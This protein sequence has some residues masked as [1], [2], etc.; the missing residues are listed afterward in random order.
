MLIYIIQS[1][2]LMNILTFDIEDW[3]I[4]EKAGLGVKSEWRKRLDGYLESILAILDERG[5]KATFFILGK[6][7]DCAPEVVLKID[8]A[9]HHIG[10]HSYSHTFLRNFSYAEAEEDTRKGIDTVEQL[11]GKKVTAYRAPAFSIT[12]ENKYMFEIL[13]KYGIETDASIFPAGR[14][15]GGFAGFES[16]KPLIVQY[17]GIKMKEFPIPMTDVFGKRIAYSGGGYFRLFPY[18]KIKFLVS[19]SSYVMTYFH[20]KD[21]DAGQP[22]RYHGLENESAPI[23]YF[24]NYYGLNQCFS[25]FQKLIKSFDFMSLKE[26]ESIVDFTQTVQL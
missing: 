4:Y 18:R 23:R 14:A 22:R 2:A 15:F 25:K 8:R 10:S 6:M 19:R 9:G 13:H 24:K 17:N 11:I 5:F 1:I 21:M 3:W 26:A 20:I 7:V 12:P 16:D